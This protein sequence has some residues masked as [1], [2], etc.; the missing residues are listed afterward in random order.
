M[1]VQIGSLVFSF[2]LTG[3]NQVL[4]QIDLVGKGLQTLAGIASSLNLE[5][6]IKD[7]A[8]FAA[9]V[10]N[11]GTIINSIGQVA[12]YSK[13]QLEN[14]T[15]GIKDLGITTRVARE[16]LISFVQANL[17]LSK[18]SQLARVAQD[19]AAISSTNSSEA[20][21]RIITG[22][23]RSNTLILRNI[24]IVINLRQ[25]YESFA[26][27]NSRVVDS[28]SANE[29]QQILLNEVIKRGQLIV[30]AYQSSL[31]DVYKSY[32]T[33]ARLSEEA[34]KQFGEQFIPVLGKV[35]AVIGQML[36]AYSDLTATQKEVIAGLA[37]FTVALGVL[38]PLV[39]AIVTG[40][41]TMASAIVAVNISLGP[42]IALIGA[43]L[44][45][46]YIKYLAAQRNAIEAAKES[47]LEIDKQ[48]DVYFQL[49]DALNTV[50]QLGPK[51][52]K[53]TDEQIEYNRAVERLIELNPSVSSALRQRAEDYQALAAAIK[54]V[55]PDSARTVDQL[56]EDLTDNKSSAKFDA[57]RALARA[58]KFSGQDFTKFS[59]EDDGFLRDQA[60]QFDRAI[61]KLR[62]DYIKFGEIRESASKP[63]K[64]ISFTEL[65]DAVKHIELLKAQY[66]A[67][68]K[69]LD[70]A[71]SKIDS[72]ERARLAADIRVSNEQLKLQE[73]AYDLIIR[74]EKE[75]F[76]ERKRLFKD[77]NLRILNDF[78]ELQSNISTQFLTDAEVEAHINNERLAKLQQIKDTE[79]GIQKA[80]GEGRIQDANEQIKELGRRK[81]N[82]DIEL[83]ILRK[84]IE[85]QRERGQ[86]FLEVRAENIRAKL[87]REREDIDRLSN[88]Y[89]E[90]ITGISSPI[91][92]LQEDLQKLIEESRR[93][94]KEY[95]SKLQ[96]I[97][98]QRSKFQAQ[99]AESQAKGD[100]LGLSQAK[101]SLK[102]VEIALE[103]GQRTLANSRIRFAAEERIK[104]L[105]IFREKQRQ[106]VEL[107]K[108]EKAL[109][110]RRRDLRRD[111]QLFDRNTVKEFNEGQ[112]AITGFLTESQD[113]FDA[114]N[115]PGIQTL[116]DAF[117]N[118]KG[119]IDSAKSKGGFNFKTGKDSQ[120]GQA[121]SIIE[122][123]LKIAYEKAIS[124][125]PQA[126]GELQAK[127]RQ[128]QDR[129]NQRLEEREKEIAET[130]DDSDK[131]RKKIQE[132]LAI[133]D[134]EIAAI[135]DFIKKQKDLLDVTDA[136]AKSFK[137]LS[138]LPKR[139]ADSLAAQQ[140]K[141][142]NGGLLLNPQ[143]PINTDGVI[144]STRALTSDI[145]SF[146][147][148]TNK[149]FN[150]ISNEQTKTSDRLAA[151][152]KQ[153]YDLLE[154]NKSKR[155]AKRRSLQSTSGVPVPGD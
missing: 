44:V 47:R 5:S 69:E 140:I 19:A 15:Q 147:N 4:Q 126:F 41:G 108:E 49:R 56:K 149:L 67:A 29:K 32:T 45:G 85:N 101:K 14:L 11:L 57:T 36:K 48:T 61:E 129:L 121:K 64:P 1:A 53:T 124:E 30:G 104:D 154:T 142:A 31:V 143:S 42:L 102:E 120:L 73:T 119:L 99:A 27:E 70:D 94:E 58:N 137:D 134:R 133:T 109:F 87:E 113:K 144:G 145:S 78:L 35:I 28:L 9:K 92:K 72:L 84:D 52:K 43:G 130:L 25:L 77:S 155:E 131:E 51:I 136:L 135:G 66:I 118:A 37:A 116:L 123:N 111:L 38:G 105:E 98:L 13:G 76:D 3:A 59:R 18:A 74:K 93:T 88:S 152:E 148:L 122:D 117:N 97:Q 23:Q 106:F 10:E 16:S 128:I 95:T 103:L 115:L 2:Q 100:P 65:G 151:A 127:Y 80:V 60:I 83:S 146:A 86:A 55:S 110:D 22:V 7:N 21:E 150:E 141:G 114:S 81:A 50:E 34:S 112:K 33:L 20:F 75:Q 79:L 62:N 139:V 82:L 40:I 90:L 91:I 138:E 63:G 46:A 6:F 125:N 71:D 24:G 39:P 54:A 12:G 96:N 17:D 89:D 68:I 8:L 153:L 26:A 107:Y 132:K